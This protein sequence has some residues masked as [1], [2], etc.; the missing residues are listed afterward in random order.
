MKFPGWLC[1]LGKEKFLKITSIFGKRR[2]FWKTMKILKNMI[3]DFSL[4][5]SWSLFRFG[6][7]FWK[8]TCI[9]WSFFFIWKTLYI[10]KKGSGRHTLYCDEN[11]FPG[12]HC[13]LGKKILEGYV[14]SRKKNTW[15]F[16]D[17]PVYLEISSGRLC[18]FG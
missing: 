12:R 8:T 11:I 15:I 5:K 17:D 6:K 10:C 7:K 2:F 13:I 14:H 9:L 3:H 16:L 4:T 1:I 18:S